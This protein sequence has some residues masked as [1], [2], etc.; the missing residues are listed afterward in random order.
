MKN[1]AKWLVLFLLSVICL[2]FLCACGGGSKTVGDVSKGLQPPLTNPFRKHAEFVS[3]LSHERKEKLKELV[4]LLKERGTKRD[5]DEI[6]SYDWGAAGTPN[7]TFAI[8]EE[9]YKQ[10]SFWRN[11]E[12][13]RNVTPLGNFKFYKIVPG[14]GYSL[15][16]NPDDVKVE[17]IKPKAFEQFPFEMEKGK[18][19]PNVLNYASQGDYSAFYVFA[20]KFYL[21]APFI[22]KADK[23]NEVPITVFVMEPVE[24]IK[25]SDK[26][27]D[28][29]K[30]YAS[31][32]YYKQLTEDLA[33]LEFMLNTC[34]GNYPGNERL[35]DEYR[36][37]A[38]KEL[39]KEL[40]GKNS[41][42]NSNTTSK[43]EETE[44][45]AQAFGPSNGQQSYV[46]NSAPQVKKQKMFNP[47]DTPQ[48]VA[49]MKGVSGTSSSS[50]LKEGDKVYSA[51]NIIDSNGHT[52]WAD[53]VEGL[54]IGESIT[55]NFNQK[56]N[57]SGFRIFNGHQKSQDLY[58][59]NSRPTVLRVIGSDG[60]NVVY[61]IEDS[62]YEQDIYFDKMISVDNIKLVIEKVARGSKYE[63][64]CIS[65]L[66]FF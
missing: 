35:W 15:P 31:S 14:S 9:D 37:W 11:D 59:K 66:I 23:N 50:A 64:T 63:D 62:I 39:E 54:G 53:G 18:K 21:A 7:R 45:L 34:F 13:G 61:N 42:N 51:S 65:E 52:C 58:N 36:S 24:F 3:T 43:A 49:I 40:T 10:V 8:N 44:K 57:I 17:E 19:K 60:S 25:L 41:N 38:A 55:I 1:K 22:G 56:Y 46:V 12:G 26:N 6:G 33:Y 32:I 2:V 29:E 30:P 47:V 5:Y 27:K 20:D 16:K 48:S 4:Y 28:L